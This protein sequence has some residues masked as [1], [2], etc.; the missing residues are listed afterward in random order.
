MLQKIKSDEM[1]FMKPVWN[2]VFQKEKKI[3]VP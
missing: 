1:A 3:F 2:I